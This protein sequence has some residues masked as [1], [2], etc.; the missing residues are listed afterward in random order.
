MAEL[1]ALTTGINFRVRGLRNE[2]NELLDKET[3]MWFQRSHALWVI[4]GDKNS[5]YFHNRATQ[6][7][8]KNKID[9]TRNASGE[10]CL[11]P[12]QVATEMLNFFSNL[13]SSTRTCQPEVA[14]ETVQCI[15]TEEMNRELLLEF[16]EK[17]VQVALN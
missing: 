4:H 10:W 8:R 9:L 16:T 15:A 11:D 13:F 3:R 17:E 14:L 12:R 6:R 7:F 1:E 5:K 2:V